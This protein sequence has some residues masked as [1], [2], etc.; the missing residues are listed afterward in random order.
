MVRIRFEVALK[1]ILFWFFQRR[2]Y[3]QFF[4]LYPT[5]GFKNEH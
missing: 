4:M 3:K 2:E 5:P 1:M